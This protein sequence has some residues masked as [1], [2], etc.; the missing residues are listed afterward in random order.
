MSTEGFCQKNQNFSADFT[1]LELNTL[2]NVSTILKGKVV[3]NKPSNLLTFDINFPETLRWIVKDSVLTRYRGDT[4]VSESTL[5]G[6]QDLVVFKE[7]LE[8]KSNDF[9]LRDHG[10]EMADVSAEDGTAFVKW[11]PPPSLKNFV[12]YATTSAKSNLLQGV[13][14]TDLDD[15]DFNT[16]MFDNYQYFNDLPIPL[17]ITQHFEGKEENIYKTIYF[18]N[19]EVF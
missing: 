6:Y 18:K 9:G 5:K 10:F 14:F 3:F 15:K 8:L 12:K 16:T 19:V 2:K 4:I 11:S 13:I 17:K 1:I 7:L